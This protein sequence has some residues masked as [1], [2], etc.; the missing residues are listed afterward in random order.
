MV[1]HAR[2]AEENFIFYINRKNVLKTAKIKIESTENYYLLSFNAPE[3]YLICGL[4][5]NSI[6]LPVSEMKYYPLKPIE[7][8]LC[9]ITN[10]HF[11]IS[12]N[13]FRIQNEQVSW[14]IHKYQAN[15]FYHDPNVHFPQ[16]QVIAP[17]PAFKFEIVDDGIFEDKRTVTI[18]S[19]EDFTH[20][21]RIYLMLENGPIMNIMETRSLFSVP[22]YEQKSDG[23]YYQS[24]VMPEHLI[25]GGRLRLQ[26]EN[27]SVVWSDWYTPKRPPFFSNP[28]GRNKLFKVESCVHAY[29]TTR[30]VTI[31]TAEDWNSD[32]IA[33]MYGLFGSY[34]PFLVNKSSSYYRIEPDG[35]FWWSFEIEQ[36]YVSGSEIYVADPANGERLSPDFQTEI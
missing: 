10:V 29:E 26:D 25:T 8:Y 17:V 22:T 9:V 31:S 24:F 7:K 12:A 21:D 30:R 19:Q 16:D 2:T 14:K 4:M 36:Q 15:H 20:I 32:V 18:R 27:I 6:L 5:A 34:E 33:L 3:D 28:V 35:R 13:E 23:F 1:N 11:Y